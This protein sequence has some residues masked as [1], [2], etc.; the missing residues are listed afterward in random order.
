[1]RRRI[2]LGVF[3]G[4]VTARFHFI[5]GRWILMKSTTLPSPHDGANRKNTGL[6]QM[7]FL[8]Q[9]IGS[10]W[11]TNG[12]K[13]IRKA[14]KMFKPLQ[15]PPEAVPISGIPIIKSVLAMRKSV[16]A[17]NSPKYD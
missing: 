3:G 17:S 10:I 16:S 13:E 14:W 4:S 8:D 9:C 12:R 11:K 1:M 7:V 15:P 5:C 6:T 2:V